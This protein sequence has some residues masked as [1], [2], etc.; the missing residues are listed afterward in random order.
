MIL[1]NIRV[2]E[3]CFQYRK[4]RKAGGNA[5]L[6]AEMLKLFA[7]AASQH[8]RNKV[9]QRWTHENHAEEIYSNQFTLKKI[10]YIH[11][12][13]GKDGNRQAC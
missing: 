1:R 7:D 6:S 9:F 13:P 5:C 3:C 2:E 4:N 8:Q 11:D 12:K 10:K